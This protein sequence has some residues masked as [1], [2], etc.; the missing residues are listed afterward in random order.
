M[1]LPEALQTAVAAALARGGGGHRATSTALSATYRAG[2][3]SAAIDLGAYL[4]ARLPATYAAVERVLSELRRHRPGFAPGSLLDAGSGPGTA[5][6]A[7]VTQWPDLA[8]VTFLDTAPAFLALAAELAR[9]GPGAL[10]AARAFRGSLLDLPQ[11]L[12]ADLVVAAYAMAELPLAQ[13]GPVAEGLWRASGQVLVLVEPGTPQGFARLRAARQRLLGLGAVVV[14]PCTHAAACPFAG[15]DWCHFSIRLARSRAHMHAK[16]ASVP[17]E[18]ERFAYLVL[19]RE[20]ALTPGARIVTPPQHAKPGVALRLCTLGRLETRH[21]A[22]R[23]A[24][25]YK[26]ARKYDWGDLVDPA[27][28]E[29]AQ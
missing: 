12:A 8:A 7:A 20:G 5:S 16:G 4:V 14:A 9:Q 10:P 1:S 19:A 3:S 27:T 13:A 26:K 6:W 29:D 28:K 24:A 22:R 11:G 18:D 15:D 23:D 21:I 17:F 25:A 2:G